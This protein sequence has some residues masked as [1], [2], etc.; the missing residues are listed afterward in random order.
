MKQLFFCL[1]LAMLF[2][3]LRAQTQPLSDEYVLKR[4]SERSE[5][6][7]NSLKYLQT[8]SP[9]K[10]WAAFNLIIQYRPENREIVKRSGLIMAE[11]PVIEKYVTEGITKLP[12]DFYNDDQRGEFLRPL[13]YVPAPWS[14]KLLGHYLTDETPMIMPAATPDDYGSHENSD[15]AVVGL[16]RMGF[17][18]APPDS[19][20]GITPEVKQAWHVWWKANGGRVEQRIAEINPGYYKPT[21]IPT[22]RPLTPTPIIIGEYAA[23]PSSA[24][25]ATTVTPETSSTPASAAPTGQTDYLIYIIG[26]LLA[27]GALGAV[28]WAFKKQS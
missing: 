3:Q 19:P 17:S 20:S 4:V 22:P 21:P 9:E 13:G 15:Y 16:Q 24:S 11:S 12:Y 1:W 26:G 28:I 10:A 7:I 5:L 27:L 6:P 23:T 8:S 2:N 14:L 18:D 25:K